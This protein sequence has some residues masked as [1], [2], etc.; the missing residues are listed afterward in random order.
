MDLKG[1]TAL[2]LGALGRAGSA[3]AR[4]LCEEGAGVMLSARRQAEGEEYAT[5]LRNEGF[6][7]G[8]VPSDVT[9]RDQLRAAAEG[10]VKRFG[11]IDILANCFSFDYLRY[12]IEDAED[13]WDRVIAVNFKGL[14]HAC[15]EVLQQMVRQRYGRIITLTSDSAKV[16]ATKEAAQSGTKAAVVAFSKSLAREMA[17][18]NVTVNVVSLGPTAES[19]GPPRG[20]SAEGWTSFMRL[21]PFG[22]PARPSEVAALVAFLAMR[23]AS[24][25][26]GQAISVSGGLVMS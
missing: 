22:R 10:T 4:K 18:H 19:S 15:Q 3:V 14:M 25:I 9:Q 23:D 12:F 17:R 6:D 21:I 5:L 7:V 8:F 2:V 20:V 24:F 13:S 1:Q 11:R 16:G 26:T